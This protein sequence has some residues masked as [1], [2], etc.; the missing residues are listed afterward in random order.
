MR[1]VAPNA[2]DKKKLHI[3]SL[4]VNTFCLRFPK[5][6]ASCIKIILSA[7]SEVPH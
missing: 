4:L 1:G 6:R 5:A 3:G 2:F 7:L